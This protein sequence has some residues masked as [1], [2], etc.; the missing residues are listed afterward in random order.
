MKGLVLSGG[1]GTRLRPITATCAKQLV[2]IANKPI[3][4]YGLEALVKAG[5]RDLGIIVGETRKEIMAAVGDGSKWGARATYLEQEKPLGL[6]HA[7]L[8][9]EEYLGDEPF[10]MYLGD[11]LLTGG[12]TE[13]VDEFQKYQPNCQILLAEVSH[14]EQFGVAELSG[15]RVVK[16]E[17]KPKNPK[18]N[19]ALVGVC[20]F[21][22]HIFQ[23]ARALK[24][25]WRN[26]LEIVDAIQ[27]LI[28]NGYN[29]RSHIISGW[30][31]DTGRLE[32]MLE[33]NRVVLDTITGNIEGF[34]DSSSRIEGRVVIQAGAEIINSV[35][36]G[37]AI[38]GEKS[39]I[40]NSFIGPFTSV[41]HQA[42]IQGSELEH[43]I[44]LGNSSIID[45]GGKI[46]DSLVGKN[47]ELNRSNL[48]PKAYRFMVGDNSRVGIL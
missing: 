1:Q 41:H 35:V 47:V 14:P 10:V 2:P 16:L 30:W 19:L 4:F 43:S 21:D 32:D 12:I 37:P 48:R 33:A 25:S 22:K 7:V 34:V 5:I 11:N 29:V 15:G 28:D 46:V 27:Y 13:F 24:P 40:I 18:S 39:R 20:M 45:I 44:I 31:K 3:L 17:E 36:R 6:A 9:G 8:V 42:L 38:I 26:E 23:A